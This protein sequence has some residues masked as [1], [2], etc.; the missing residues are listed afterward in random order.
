MNRAL[1]SLLI[2]AIII[3]MN[4]LEAHA[5]ETIVKR[6]FYLKSYTPRNIAIKSAMVPGWGQYANHQTGKA[7]VISTAFFASVGSAYILHQ[8]AEEKYDDYK[9]KG[10]TDDELY[11]DYETYYNG[12]LIAG[13]IAVLVWLYGITDAYVF[14]K[15]E[16]KRIEE[17][18]WQLQFDHKQIRL[19]YKKK[20]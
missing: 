16:I 20:F 8:V 3:F 2:G 1:H 15:D 4:G 6:K 5:G 19:A 11:D 14:A 9:D 12:A 18:S 10:L 7:Y 13:G 17:Y